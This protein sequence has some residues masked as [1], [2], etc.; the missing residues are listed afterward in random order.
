MWALDVLARAGFTFDSSM[1]P[2]RVVGDPGLSEGAPPRPLYA[3]RRRLRVSSAGFERRLGQNVPLGLGWGLRMSSPERVRKAI[4]AHN[5]RGTPVALAVHPWEIDPDPPRVRLPLAKSFAHYFCLGGFRSRLERVIGSSSFAPMGDVSRVLD[6]LTMTLSVRFGTALAACIILWPTWL[7]A[8]E[9]KLRGIAIDQSLDAEPLPADLPPSVPLIVRLSIEPTAYSEL[10]ADRTLT[11]LRDVVGVYRSRGMQV[12][13]SLGSFPAGNGD[14]DRWRQFVRSIVEQNRTTIA[15]YQLGQVRAGSVPDVSRYVYLL[16][17]AAVQIRSVDPE[18]LVIQGTVPAVS[19]DWEERVLRGGAGP[20]VDGVAIDGPSSDEDEPFRTAVHQMADVVEREKPSASM[21]LGPFRLPQGPGEA[22]ARVI[23]TVLRSLGTSIQVTAFALEVA[24]LKVALAAAAR[25]PDLLA[26][27]LVSLDEKVADLRI[28]R[29]SSNVTS[30][31]PHR[32]LRQLE[33]VRYFSCL[34]G[35][36]G[37][38]IAGPRGYGCHWNDAHLTRSSQRNVGG[39]DPLS[40]ARDAGSA[41]PRSS[42]HDSPSDCRLQLC[43]RRQLR[44]CRRSAE[45]DRAT[46]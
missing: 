31:I 46:R 10:T 22:T 33:R 5:E 39:A 45:R 27:D 43:G 23:D 20:Y 18:A 36:S 25:M 40:K 42:A 28:M 8:A 44:R 24:P 19:S 4:D 30:S 21:L 6:R 12:I 14:D 32:L 15:A 26:G 16:K 17:L 35:R 34:L 37:K 13:L 3:G 38:R 11:R 29:G 41:S 2:L 7:S 9:T 1:A